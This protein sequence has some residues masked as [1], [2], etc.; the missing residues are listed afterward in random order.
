MQELIDY[1]N[2]T[3]KLFGFTYTEDQSRILKHDTELTAVQ[4]ENELSYTQTSIRKKIGD[5]EDN[6]C[7][8]EGS[9]IAGTLSITFEMFK[10]SMY[11]IY[12]ANHICFKFLGSAE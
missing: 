4:T 7:I 3:K 9:V 10:F 12:N 6:V 2:R 11:S 8:N 1:Q 5:N